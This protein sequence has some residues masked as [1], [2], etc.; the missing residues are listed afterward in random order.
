MT[1]YVRVQCGSVVMALHHEYVLE[2]GEWQGSHRARATPWR[3]QTVPLRVLSR[4]LGLPESQPTSYLV[5]QA[6]GS[7]PAMLL[8]DAIQRLV[9]LEEAQF[10]QLL[11]TSVLDSNLVNEACQ[12]ED[13]QVLLR[14]SPEIARQH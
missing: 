13:G 8:V 9:D 2:V 7:P 11:D 6:P 1:A 5:I 3:D 4:E 12:L 14:L 10:S